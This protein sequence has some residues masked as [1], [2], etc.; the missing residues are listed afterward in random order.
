M[1]KRNEMRNQG[2]A[3]QFRRLVTQQ[4]GLFALWFVRNGICQRIHVIKHLFQHYLCKDQAHGHKTFVL[5][6]YLNH[7]PCT[8]FVQTYFRLRHI[9]NTKFSETLYS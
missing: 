2:R 8:K 6:T 7:T 9:K 3:F 4:A 1:A 5:Q